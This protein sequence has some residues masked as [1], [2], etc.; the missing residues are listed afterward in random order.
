MD[1]LCSLEKENFHPGTLDS[2]TASELLDL[3]RQAARIHPVSHLQVLFLLF[4]NWRP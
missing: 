1:V 2:D 3:A 4:R